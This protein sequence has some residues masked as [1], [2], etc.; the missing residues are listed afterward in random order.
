MLIYQLRVVLAFLLSHI[1]CASP[2]Q[3]RF[4]LMPFAL[5]TSLLCASYRPLFDP[6]LSSSR[7][8]EW[9]EGDLLHLSVCGG[10]RAATNVQKHLSDELF[11]CSDEAYR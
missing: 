11:D 3:K 2:F 7:D 5:S 6:C 1:L 10:H 9:L 8:G 4:V